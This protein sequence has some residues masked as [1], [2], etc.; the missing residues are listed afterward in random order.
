MIDLRRIYQIIKYGWLHADQIRKKINKRSRLP[1]FIDILLCYSKYHLWSNQYLQ[2]GF[3]SLEKNERERLGELYKRKNLEYEEIKKDKL[4]NRIFLNKWK[5]YYWE[6]GYDDRRKKRQRAY[7]QRYN[8]GEKC[9]ISFDVHIERNHFLPGTIKV[10]NNVMLGKHVYIDYSGSVV[11]KDNVQ[12]TNGVIVESHY[13]AFHSDP[14]ASHTI[15]T[16]TS[17]IIEEGAVIG[18]R[19]IILASC[20]YIGRNARVGAGAVVTKDVP[21]NSL[22][23]GVPARVIKMYQENVIH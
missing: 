12:I 18:S 11:I 19:A 13:H 4:E 20:H 22:V 3:Y 8:M 14:S 23:V 15:V 16:P 9:D 1:F 17:L 10:G 5:S 21:D 2:E 7:A 6:L